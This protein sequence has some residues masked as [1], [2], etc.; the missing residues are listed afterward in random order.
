MQRWSAR[1]RCHPVCKHLI[2]MI[3]MIFRVHLMSVH[4]RPD[5][6]RL[7]HNRGMLLARGTASL[8]PCLRAAPAP[9]GAT[10]MTI[11]AIC[12]DCLRSSHL[13]PSNESKQRSS[14]HRGPDR[15]RS[16]ELSAA[17]VCNHSVVSRGSTWCSQRGLYC[18]MAEDTTQ[19]RHLYQAVASDSLSDC[20]LGSLLSSI[21]SISIY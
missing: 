5:C 8:G 10:P 16:W 12:S 11:T 20:Y 7:P 17:D 13:L 4:N 9:L 14:A 19:L 15:S 6:C 18:F 21:N 1:A 2:F 3:T